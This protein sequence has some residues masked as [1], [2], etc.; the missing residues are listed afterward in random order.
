VKSRTVGIVLS[1]AALSAPGVAL[2]TNGYFSHGYGI[3]AK[4]MAGAGIALPQDAMAAATNPAGMALVGSRMDLGADVFMPSRSGE[5]VG[6]QGIPPPYNIPSLDGKYSGDGRDTF[7]IPEFGYNRMVNPRLAVGLTVYGNGGMNTSY[8]ASPF[9]MLGGSNPAGVDLSQLFIA[10]TVAWRIN[11]N[12]AIGVSLNLAYQRFSASGLGPFEAFNLS[13]APGAVTNREHDGATG[14]GLR[15]GW[16]GRIND[17]VSL[18][19]TYQTKTRMGRFDKYAGLFADQGDFDIPANYGVGIA[20]RAT[21]ALTIAADLQKIEY[22]GVNAVGN[23][24]SSLFSGS[25]LGATNG[26]GFGWRDMTVFKLGAS[27]QL[28][29]ALTLRAG[30]STGRQPIPSGETFFNILA[31]GVVEDHLTLGATW[32]L[33]NGR[34][35]SVAYMHAFSKA[36]KG[37]GSIPPDF[38]G[39]EANLRMHE[40]SIGISYGMKF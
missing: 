31:P 27:Y 26:P 32:Q 10:P 18:G 1:L 2:A 17:M 8:E 29:P 16:N 36:V 35:L 13:S 3:K 21:P 28:N 6:N 39:G 11:D 30:Y 38:G 33:G 15:V 9:A 19:A 22:S 23:S 24:I 12:H 7:L 37:A 20:I 25:P 4:G 5:I 14:W 40:N 34:E